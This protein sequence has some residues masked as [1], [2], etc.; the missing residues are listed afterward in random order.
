[1][2]KTET[3]PKKG[4]SHALYTFFSAIS[5]FPYKNTLITY[6]LFAACL[7]Q[8]E[9]LCMQVYVQNKI[10]TMLMPLAACLVQMELL[11]IQNKITR[12]TCV[13]NYNDK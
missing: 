10:N 2:I 12:I 7:V 11:C 5:V 1:M 13:H 6:L 3:A 4:N 9:L 8:M